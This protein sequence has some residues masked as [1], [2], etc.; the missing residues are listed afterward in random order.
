[1]TAEG[2][3]IL[4]QL[5]LG[6]FAGQSMKLRMSLLALTLTMWP[7]TR[8]FAESYFFSTGNPDFRLGALSRPDSSQ[9]IETE[10][11]DDFVLT[12]ATSINQ[13]T[14]IGGIVGGQYATANLSHVEVEIYHVFPTDS[15]SPPSGNVPTRVNSPADV[16]IADATRDSTKGALS[17]TL[18][19]LNPNLMISNTV[20]K[21]ISKIPNQHTG[22]EGSALVTEVEIDITFTPPIFLPPGHYFFRPE[23]LVSS[24]T[25]LYLS[26]PKPIVPP[27][28][29]FPSG[30][31]DLQAWMRNANLVP[32][33][34]RIGT[35]IVGGTTYNM[36][37]SLTGNTVP[38]AGT[39]PQLASG[40]GWDTALTLVNTGAS[41]GEAILGFF[42]GD[43]SP[44][45]LPLT[46]PQGSPPAVAATLDQSLNANALLVIDSQQA[47]PHAQ[48]GSAQLFTMGSVGGFSIFKY[49]PT[50][51]EA[52]VPLETRNAPAYVLAFDNTG[53]VVTG[54]AL[55]NVAAQSAKIPVVI[56]DDTGNEINTDTISLAA[57]GHT[58]FLLSSNYAVTA[59]KRGTV[60]FDT[61]TSGRIAVLGLRANGGALT[62]LP[63]LVTVT[64]GSGSMAQVAS[65][66]GWQTTF[67]LVNTGTSSAQVQLSFFGDGGNALSLPL[68]FV[69]SGTI[70]NA[71]T[72]T[73]TIAAGGTLVVLTQ[74]NNAG[75]TVAG[76]VQLTTAGGISGFAIF[77]YNPT[78][79]EAVVPL[80]TRNAN[81]Y[82]LAFDNTNG[83]ATG[84]ALSNVS[85]QAVSVPVI[86]RDD[87]GTNL[88]TATIDL[89][90]LGHT[91]FILAD[92]YPSVAEKRGTIEFDT[93]TGA[94]ISALGLRGTPSGAVT[95][96][97]VLAK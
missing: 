10:T 37:F 61:P 6:I 74:G 63:A 87:T 70:T 66:G 48:V 67:T 96:I 22:G 24:G 7:T 43:G 51:Q 11:A 95:T 38:V 64:A 34:L 69:Q 45:S 85:Q 15:A 23:V 29:P 16:E 30:S 94:Q 89:A 46:F 55:A 77:R 20:I 62:T 39:M 1:M 84:L 79:Q 71:S 81:A 4:V 57:E 59:G 90:P 3:P 28:T 75:A 2:R 68:K 36:T 65:G 78:G 88:G 80:E 42:G 91:A 18:K 33:W 31:T 26:A 76:S 83:I 9:G 25:F 12:Q 21:G 54:V 49:L 92:R 60:E 35:D 58:S 86:L 27:G 72:I 50:G 17:P 93:P 73:Q 19:L 5:F 44:L 14:I 82:V 52:V 8:G 97:P 32:D 41:S 13:A 40:G 53:T 56:R 47:N